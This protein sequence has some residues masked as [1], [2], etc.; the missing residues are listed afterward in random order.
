MERPDRRETFPRNS[1]IK[2]SLTSSRFQLHY[3]IQPLTSPRKAAVTCTTEQ[4]GEL[5]KNAT[6][7]K[8]RETDSSS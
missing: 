5:D 4:S 7:A 3:D 1:D 6:A 2:Q 8:T